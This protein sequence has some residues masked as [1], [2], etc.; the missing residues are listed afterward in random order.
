[1]MLGAKEVKREPWEHFKLK[2][3]RAFTARMSKYQHLR[4]APASGSIESCAKLVVVE[5]P[6][7][8]APS[9]GKPITDLSSV[10][11]G[12]YQGIN[13]STWLA[14]NPSYLQGG[15]QA[16]LCCELGRA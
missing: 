1:M 12:Q 5:Q 4:A 3:H 2:H 11:T 13:L 16:E 7:E 8:E 6:S 9:T 14:A 15:R 10:T